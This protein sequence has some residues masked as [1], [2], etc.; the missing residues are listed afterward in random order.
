MIL[1]FSQITITLFFYTCFWHT[2][3]GLSSFA[4]WSFGWRE[5]RLP[6]PLEQGVC[7]LWTLSK[8]I[9]HCLCLSVVVCVA[10]VWHL[11][12]TPHHVW[13]CIQ[14]IHLCAHKER[15][16]R[17]SPVFG[18]SYSLISVVCHCPLCDSPS[19]L[20]PAGFPDWLPIVC[21]YRLLMSSPLFPPPL[22]SVLSLTDE[23]NKMSP[24]CPLSGSRVSSN[25]QR[26]TEANL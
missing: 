4:K 10:F 26:H 7:V 13:R 21:V 6:L 14:H 25:Q 9:K 2:G 16:S 24:F 18:T 8:G 17:P 19:F 23:C 20:R 15:S 11:T 3:I 1:I 5:S 22:C 12:V